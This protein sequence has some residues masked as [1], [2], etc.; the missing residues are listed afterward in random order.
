M[1]KNSILPFLAFLKFFFTSYTEYN[2]VEAMVAVLGDLGL[3]EFNAREAH[4]WTKFTELRLFAFRTF[5]RVA[6]YHYFK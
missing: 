3:M 4:F 5:L 2:C 6:T 1:S